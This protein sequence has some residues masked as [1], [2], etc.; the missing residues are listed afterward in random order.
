MFSL[1]RTCLLAV[2]VG[3]LLLTASTSADSA[4]PKGFELVSENEF[5]GLYVNMS[6][7][8]IAVLVK[9]DGTV[10]FS[11]PP[12]RATMETLTRGTGKDRLSAQLVITYYSVNQKL[13]M[14]SYNDSIKH[15]QFKITPIPGG[16]RV[17]YELGQRWLDSDYVPYMISEERFN[18]LVL[19]SIENERDRRTLRN[20]YYLFTLEEG[21]VDTDKF[22]I[23]G[24]DLD[25]LLGPYGLKAGESNL[26]ASDKRRILQEYL[27]RVRDA[28]GYTTLGDIKT[29]DIQGSLGVPILIQKWTLMEWDKQALVQYFKAAGY[30]PEDVQADHEM[31]GIQP[32]YPDLRNFKISVEYV[33]DGDDLVARIPAGSV[34]YPIE[35][36]D[37]K[38]DRVMSYP[39]TQINLL[40]YFG[41]ANTE[42]K[43]YLFVPE[44]S[45]ALIYLNNGKT[46]ADIYSRY[47]Y[48]RDYSTMPLTEYSTSLK[49]QIFLPV[50][51]IKNGDQA[52]LAIIEDG[53]AMAQICAV[54]AGM[55]DSY[56]RVWPAFDFIP[57]ARVNLQSDDS[58]ADLRHLRQLAMMMYQ[59]RAY[60]GDITVRYAFLSGD[61][62]NYT[63]MAKRYRDYL[64]GEH[65]LKPV[66]RSEGLPLIV[67]VIGSF[68]VT[69]PVF[70]IP[71]NVAQAATTYQQT[72]LIVSDLLDSGVDDIVVRYRGWLK[73]GMNHI[74]PKKA[75][76]E[77]AVGSKSDLNKL[78]SSLK[79]C[80]VQLYPDVTFLTV[81]RNGLLDGFITFRDASRFLSRK[82]AFIPKHNLAS[83]QIEAGTERPIVSPRLLPELVG[84][85]MESYKKLGISGISL[86]GLGKMLNSDF[87]I[88][89]TQLVDRQQAEDIVVKQAQLI[90]G[91]NI[92]I[93][94]TGGNAYM[95]PYAKYVIEAPMNC[96]G[97]ALLDS[98]VPFFHIA[99]SGY[100]VRA[101]SPANLSDLAGRAWLLK[102][103]ETGCVPYF[104]VSY[105]PS[106]DMKNTEFDHF[107]ATT[108]ESVRNEILETYSKI[109]QISGDL[110]SKAI[111]D[112][113]VIV[114]EVFGTTYEDGTTIIVNY[115]VDPVEVNGV[116]VPA[117]DYLVIAGGG[118]SAS[119]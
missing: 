17:D 93:M 54:V 53:D 60:Q 21:Y 3:L 119:Y 10:W 23:L 105:S 108:Y 18:D 111:V 29:E 47:V 69:K 106:S 16:V 88:D 12:D 30:T 50:Y 39:L 87:R 114:P 14:D 82:S 26:R 56:N 41:A 22:S 99:A 75:V 36:F 63:G 49:G 74:Y 97:L 110:W 67:D 113:E 86:S 57:N 8:E 83:H 43:G 109:A 98:S 34:T 46:T 40:P 89:V 25:T 31:F 51:G 48:G 38:L 68:D 27:N 84:G 62:A 70:G 2:I 91:M 20:S 78:V 94:V 66:D 104:V 7:A 9:A 61:E 116:V 4:I 64:V 55:R 33:L 42:A 1:R 101:G 37:Q 19:A 44:G 13:E 81:L 11:N 45:G 65:G 95:W 96:I 80:G 85:F 28:H 77:S 117:E 107:Y 24:V 79:E 58:H 115:S 103:L 112:H 90:A 15:G 71:M 32:P 52:F 72:G 5:A 118:S 76:L 102:T 92:D 100:V 35:V 6:T 73:G 59:S